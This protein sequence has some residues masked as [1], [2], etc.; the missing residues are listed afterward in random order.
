MRGKFSCARQGLPNTTHEL[1][2][3]T[4]SAI[5]RNTMQSSWEA[6]RSIGSTGIP[7]C[8][9]SPPDNIYLTAA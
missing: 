4:A 8:N 6:D 2:I 3:Q 5:L 7:D 9:F 1:A